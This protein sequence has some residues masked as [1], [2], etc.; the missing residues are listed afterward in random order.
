[1]KTT[2]VKIEGLNCLSC[3]DVVEKALEALP[4]VKSAD[5]KL[6]DV[7]TINHEDVDENQLIRT[8]ASVGDY[9]AHVVRED[10]VYQG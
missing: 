1:M 2:K 4:G 3:V 5:V 9:K 8:I 10:A 7:T 6:E